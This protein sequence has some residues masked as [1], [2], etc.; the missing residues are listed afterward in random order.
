M[1]ERLTTKVDP[2]LDADLV[3]RC[4]MS[5]GSPVRPTSSWPYEPPMNGITFFSNSSKR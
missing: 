1:D 3:Q 2:R 5:I 4:H